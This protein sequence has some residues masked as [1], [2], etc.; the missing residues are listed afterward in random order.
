MNSKCISENSNTRLAKNTILLY[1]RMFLSIIVNLYISR[2]ILN[3]LGFSDF[4]LYQVVGGIVIMFSFLNASLS[5]ATSR[6]ITFE[7]GKNKFDDLIKVF[8]ITFT[9]HLL[10]ALGVLILSETIGLWFIYHKLVIPEG[11][12]F[13]A[14]WTFHF[15]VA[16]LICNIIQVPYNACIIAHERM[17]VYAYISIADVVIKLFAVYLLYIIPWDKLI[18]YSVLMFVVA[19]LITFVYIL[20]CKR[21]FKEC[22]YLGLYDKKIAKSIFVFSA[23]D[24]YGNMCVIGSSQG[25]NILLNLFFGTVVN[26]S[27]GIANRV[28]GAAMGLS[29]SFLLAMKPQLTKLYAQNDYDKAIYLMEYSSKFAIF[30]MSLV[31]IPL[32]LEC[33]FILHIWLTEVPPYSVIFCSLSLITGIVNSLFSP[34]VNL[35]HATGYIKRLSIIGGSI[36][37][38]ILP[39]SYL[40]FKHDCLPVTTF[41]VTLCSSI[42]SGIVNLNILKKYLPQIKL[43]NYIINICLPYIKVLIISLLI[44][45]CLLY[46]MQEDWIRFILISFSFIIGM[47]ITSYFIMLSSEQKRTFIQNIISQINKKI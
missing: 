29:A 18:S 3:V 5:G 26:A 9:I 1:I 16:V 43:S 36:S 14:L 40:L 41:I 33:N 47:I 24:L 27:C 17:N 6:F 20:Y 8:N 31:A 22:R 2:V 30:L 4:G 19:L 7:L 42:I 10:I 46:N 32:T 39:I 15:S 28:G 44:P 45:I 25:Q 12:L 34:V 13:A 23:W 37:L 11:R 35:L 38:I 21:Y